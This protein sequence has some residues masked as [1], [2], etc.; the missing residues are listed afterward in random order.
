MITFKIKRIRKYLAYEAV[1]TLVQCTVTVHLDYF[2]SLYCGLP[3]K[4]IKKLQL[5]QNA[6]A[7]LIDK[8][9]QPE[10]ISHI[11]ID[12][13]WLPVTK[14]CRYKL[15]V[16]TYKT[17]HGTTPVYIYMYVTCSIGATQLDH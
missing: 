1:K 12:L 4:T 15:M 14:Q 10:S 2:N 6:A 16:L 9:S 11:L 7:R 3:L 8:I 13:Y 5:T 17:L